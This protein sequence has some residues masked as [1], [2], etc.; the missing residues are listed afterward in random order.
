MKDTHTES[1]VKVKFKKS[2]S[3]I[4]TPER[5]HEWDAG[6]D[7]TAVSKKE[8]PE[9]IQYGTGV[10]FEIPNGYVGFIVPRSSVTKRDM[11]LK[12]SIGIID[13]PYRG[14]VMFRF[15]KI[16]TTEMDK[17]SEVY[18][19][20][21]GHLIKNSFKVLNYLK[22]NLQK[23]Y[24][25]GEKIGQIIFIKLPVIQLVETTDELSET[26]RGDGGF[27]STDKK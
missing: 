15:Y 23:V 2:S 6:F 11:M 19:T 26:D 8:T 21:N 12:N 13:A 22:E 14:E 5:A 1:P 16:I 24:G 3:D 10:S 7:L 17:S 25:V 18:D 27:G 20:N 9:Y 4:P